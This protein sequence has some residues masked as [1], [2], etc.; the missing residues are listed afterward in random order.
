[1]IENRIV[2]EGL[3]IHHEASRRRRSHL[4]RAGFSRA[5]R[6]RRTGASR[7]RPRCA[8]SRGGGPPDRFSRRRRIAPPLPS[9]G[10]GDGARPRPARMRFALRLCESE[11][12]DLRRF[13]RPVGMAPRKTARAAGKCYPAR[14]RSFAGPESLPATGMPDAAGAGSRGSRPEKSRALL[15]LLGAPGQRRDPPSPGGRPAF[16]RI[17]PGGNEPGRLLA[18]TGAQ[19]PV[20]PGHGC[21]GA[22]GRN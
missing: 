13:H 8:R 18:E 16:P 7:F 22:T 15:P 12:A 5:G 1:M 17:G 11:P 20:R 6:R 3:G 4:V 21:N 19:D 9:P 14:D 10:R 2:H